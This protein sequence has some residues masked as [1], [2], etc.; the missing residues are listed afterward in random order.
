MKS[1][2]PARLVAACVLAVTCFVTP[3][4]GAFDCFLQIEGV[5]G[6][7]QISPGGIDLEAYSYDVKAPRDVA[8]GQ[9]SGKRSAVD[10]SDITCSTRLSKA[11]P[12]LMQACATGTHFPTAK[13][14]CR[15]A[16]STGAPVDF[17]VITMEDVMI[18]SYV[19]GGGGQQLPTESI[20]LNF[21]KVMFSYSF[22]AN[23]TVR[24]NWDLGKQKGI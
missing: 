2:F 24:L 5:D 9:A 3:A 23:Q 11:T 4:F 22:G 12:K 6:E 13:L 17:L 19:S 21:T 15:K 7:S 20:S 18:S 1:A 8:T 10:M 16:G 14:T